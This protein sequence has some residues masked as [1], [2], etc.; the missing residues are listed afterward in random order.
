MD[1]LPTFQRDGV[2]GPLPLLDPAQ[3]AAFAAGAWAELGQDPANPG[4]SSARLAAWHHHQDWAWDLATHP[5]ILDTVEEL[6][7]PDIVL[8]A[9]F[10]WYKPP[11]TGKRIPFHQDGAYWPIEPKK[12][13][14][15]WIALE[16]TTR[17]NGCL[18]VIPGSHRQDFSHVPVTDQ[19]SWFGQGAAG[20]DASQA[21][22]LEMPAGSVVFFDEHCLHGSDANDSDRARLACS[23]RYTSPEVRISPTGWGPDDERIRVYQVRGVDRF[24]YNEAIR[25]VP[26]PGRR[27]SA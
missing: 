22:V 23:L 15:A 14:T 4:P 3:A 17:A 20:Y 21:R 5:R 16:P 13:I 2:V 24:G 27:R 9:M 10:C 1:L 7:G 12:N 11:R 26:P 8:W 19:R 25:G 18:Q 6:L